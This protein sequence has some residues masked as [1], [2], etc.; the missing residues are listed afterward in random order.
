MSKVALASIKSLTFYSDGL[1]AARRTE[2]IPQLNCIGKA[3]DLYTPDA[4]RCTNAGGHGN[5]VDWKVRCT[6]GA[7]L[8]PPLRIVLIY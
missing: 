5:D 8:L 2:P 1:T 3:C 7:S 6:F 4:V